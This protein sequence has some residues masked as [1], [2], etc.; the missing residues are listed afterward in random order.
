[1]TKVWRH[2]D[3]NKIV[4][5]TKKHIADCQRDVETK[6]ETSLTSNSNLRNR[7]YKQKL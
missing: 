3:N 5:G 1:M 7:L 2:D 4:D 6:N